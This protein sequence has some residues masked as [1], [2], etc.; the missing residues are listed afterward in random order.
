MG[1]VLGMVQGYSGDG[2][3]MALG[4]S[5]NG[6]GMALEWFGMVWE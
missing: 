4:L 2:L 1:I 5:G 3:G 6:P